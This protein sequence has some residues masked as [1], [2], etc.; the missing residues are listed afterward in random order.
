MRRSVIALLLTVCFP[1]LVNAQSDE[2][3]TTEQLIETY[4]LNPRTDWPFVASEPEHK[5]EAIL[6]LLA[7]RGLSALQSLRDL[8]N[9]KEPIADPDSNWSLS[10]D[11][12]LLTTIRR[13]ERTE[14]PLRIDVNEGRR[15]VSAMRETAHIPVRIVNQ[16]PGQQ[17]V[18]FKFG[19]DYR[20]G[21]LSRWRVHVWDDQGARLPHI[22]R[23]G[24]MGGG[25]YSQ[26]ELAF[27]ET[28]DRVLDLDGFVRIP[29]PGLYTAKVL[30]HDSV[31]IAD[32]ENEE[33]LEELVLVA[34]DT[35]EMEFKPGPMIH[36]PLSE[37]DYAKSQTL[38]AQLG[39]ERPIKMIGSDYGTRYHAF[40]PPDSEH[41]Q[42]LLMGH[43]AVPALIE[44]LKLPEASYSQ[45]A[46]IL[47]IL[48]SILHERYLSPMEFDGAIDHYRCEFP[49]G[50]SS[51]KGPPSQEAQDRLVEEWLTFASTYIIVER[52]SAPSK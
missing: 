28:D 13:I 21:R 38:I 15:I 19:G 27:G 14:D 34:S 24:S 26:G 33:A 47:A 41:G 1:I 45:R 43:S 6:N 35:F 36:I 18:C 46:L 11:L 16:D 10:N 32:I 40:I 52:Q 31:S 42:L 49:S 5:P 7:K 9:T 30:Y 29:R 12:A 44:H 51:G 17:S 48:H 50:Y 2:S 4:K 39:P 22:G 23:I 20:S 3:A 25:L 8:R 37:D